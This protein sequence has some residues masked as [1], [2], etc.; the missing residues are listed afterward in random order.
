MNIQKVIKAHGFTIAS[1]AAK[2]KNSRGGIGIFQ[3]ALSSTLN[4]NPS[5]NKLQEIANIIGCKVGDFFA[6][7]MSGTDFTA[8][9]KSGNEFFCASSLKELEDIVSELKAKS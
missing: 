5:I 9:I 1:V 4:G 8:L 7:E 2:L 3:G 6:D